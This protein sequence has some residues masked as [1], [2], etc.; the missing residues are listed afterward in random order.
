MSK[1]EYNKKHYKQFKVDLKIEEKEN[2]E[3]MLKEDNITKAS[4]LRLAI[5]EYIA[6]RKKKKLSFHK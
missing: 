2:L 5:S 6:K 3:K 1:I 4:F